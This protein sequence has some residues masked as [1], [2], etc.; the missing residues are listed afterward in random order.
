MIP[1]TYFYVS[2]VVVDGT[3]QGAITSYTFNNVTANHT[4]LATFAIYPVINTHVNAG[5]TSL[6]AAYNAALNGDTI[7][8]QNIGFT[9]NFTANSNITIT[10]CGG[11]NSNYST[12]SGTTTITGAVT[13]SSG[14]VWM[15]NFEIN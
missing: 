8:I 12:N 10:I 14:T 4:L 13:I 5:Y 6:Q 2:D 7:L 3:D 1:N 11:Y 9:G 15:G